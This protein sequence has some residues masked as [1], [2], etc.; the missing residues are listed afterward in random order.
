MIVSSKLSLTF[1][2][3][4]Q[5]FVRI[6]HFLHEC[7]M[8]CPSRRHSFDNLNYVWWI[9]QIIT[10]LITQFPQAGSFVMTRLRAGRLRNRGSFP[11]GFF[12]FAKRRRWFRGPPTPIQREPGSLVPGIDGPVHEAHYSP[13]P[14]AEIKTACNC[15][16]THPYALWRAQDKKPHN[17]VTSSL[18]EPC[19]FVVHNPEYKKNITQS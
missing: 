13:P 19:N 3:F 8:S 14:S 4:E 5:K 12:S 2:G 6:P 7:Y 17:T 1:R 15:I 9:V 10:L 16:S 18:M 11:V